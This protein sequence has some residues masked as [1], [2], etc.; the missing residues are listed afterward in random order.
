MASVAFRNVG[1]IYAGNVE[2]LH[3]LNLTI[4]DGELLVMVGPSGCGKTTAL[5]L[6]AGLEEI[7]SGEIRIDGETVNQLSPQQRNI[8]M[9]FQNYALYPHMTVRGN[10]E[11][12]L[13]MIKIGR[14]ERQRRLQQAAELLGLTPLLERKPGQLSG[15]QRQRVAMG[16]AIVRDP[17]VFLMDEPLSNLDAG[18]RLQIRS[19]IAALQ[20]EMGTTTLYVTHDQVEAM[21]LGERVAVLAGGRL[22]Q[23]DTPQCLYQRPGNVFVAEFLGSPGMN[24]FATRLLYDA[25][26]NLCISFNGEPVPIPEALRQSPTALQDQ[27]DTLHGVIAGLRPEAFS[28]SQHCAQQRSLPVT[29]TSVEPLGHETLLY[30]DSPLQ[31]VTAAAI[32]LTT[33][34]DS[35]AGKTTMAARLPGNFSLSGDARAELYADTGKLHLFNRLGKRL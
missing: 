32:P 25:Q 1:K 22:Q 30:F 16:R 3:D 35:D 20:Q 10:L 4:S 13:K 18:L 11:F 31:T 24:F 2:A 19:E 15:G 23:V 9:V 21:T 8:A 14:K 26:D 27:D 12:P 29:V 6:L 34:A 7:T 17:A 5:R 33:A 28:T